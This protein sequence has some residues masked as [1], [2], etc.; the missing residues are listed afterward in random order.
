MGFLRIRAFTAFVIAIESSI[1]LSPKNARATDFYSVFYTGIFFTSF[2]GAI[3][4]S[5]G[6]TE[7]FLRKPD[8]ARNHTDFY[9]G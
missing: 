3:N 5:F 7:I 8:L 9:S 6:Y 4:E 2:G 1:V